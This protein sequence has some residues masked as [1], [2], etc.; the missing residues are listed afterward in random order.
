MRQL[1]TRR[2]L[3]RL[4]LDI[5]DDERAVL[6]DAL[7]G[8]DDDR[9]PGEKGVS[10]ESDGDGKGKRRAKRGGG[11]DDKGGDDGGGDEVLYRDFL[12]L[13]LAEQVHTTQGSC[14]SCCCLGPFREK[15]ERPSSRDEIG[16]KPSHSLLL[17][18]LSEM[19]S[20]EL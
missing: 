14:H 6:L 7:A 3:R 5:E 19:T 17:F 8:G 1:Q 10:F 12:E 18:W 2:F 16:G 9:A 13:V 11:D 15:K 4:K 20:P